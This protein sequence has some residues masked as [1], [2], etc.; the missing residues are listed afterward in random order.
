M[1]RTG[2]GYAAPIE[3]RVMY[4]QRSGGVEAHQ[5][6]VQCRMASNGTVV[7]MKD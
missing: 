2:T 1:I 7:A 5:S 4:R 3:F 6:V